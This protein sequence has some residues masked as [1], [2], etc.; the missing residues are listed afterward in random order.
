MKSKNTVFL[1]QNK[2]KLNRVTM[3]HIFRNLF[4]VWLIEDSWCLLFAPVLILY[5]CV[6]LVQVYEGNL[7][8]YSHRDMPV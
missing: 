5:K 8:S 4:H 3:L 7:A 2:T 1:K 6:V